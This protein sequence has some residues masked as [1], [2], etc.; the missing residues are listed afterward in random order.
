MMGGPEAASSAAG[1]WIRAALTLYSIVI[2]TILWIGFAVALLVERRW[3]DDLWVWLKD[4]PIA[5][6]IVLWILLLP[7]T[8][9]LWIWHSGWATPFKLVGLGG[10]VVWT[11]VA[12]SSFAGLVRS[13]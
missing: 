6:Q 12:I 11:A 7:I 9:G 4:L 13:T 1:D 10:V 3:I 2:F 8:I 5:F